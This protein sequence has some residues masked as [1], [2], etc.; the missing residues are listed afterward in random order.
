MIYRSKNIHILILCYV[1]LIVCLLPIT[2]TNKTEFDIMLF[3]YESYKNNPSVLVICC[4]SNGTSS[5]I[6]E[7]NEQKL[8]FVSQNI[9]KQ[10]KK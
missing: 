5:Q 2:K 6:I 4:T 7:A 10:L 8:L 1:Y 9:F 3:N